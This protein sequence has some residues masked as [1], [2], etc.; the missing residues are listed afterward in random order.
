MLYG[1]G[2]TYKISAYYYTPMAYLNCMYEI[3]KIQTINYDRNLI[4]ISRT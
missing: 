2:G 1:I 4:V 3:Q